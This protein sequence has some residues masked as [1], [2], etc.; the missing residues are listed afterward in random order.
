MNRTQQ[1]RFYSYS[2][3]LATL[4]LAAACSGDSLEREYAPPSGDPAEVEAVYERNF[5]GTTRA[6]NQTLKTFTLFVV[7]E[8]YDEEGPIAD[9][10]LET[11]NEETGKWESYPY[12]YLLDD[13]QNAYA[14]APSTSLEN[15]QNPVFTYDTQS[16]KYT[17]PTT[18]QSA[19]KIASRLDFT[20]TAVNN[21]LVMTFRDALF[22]LQFQAVNEIKD[23]RIKVKS[24]TLHNILPTGTWNF[25]KKNESTGQWTV[26][27]TANTRVNYTQEFETPVELERTKYKNITDSAFVFMPQD[28]YE[29]IWYPPDNDWGETGEEFADAQTN[30]HLY[31]EVKCQI[32]QEKD[33]K[34]LYLWGYPAAEASASKPEFESVFFPYDEYACLSDWMQGINS[35]YFLEFN[36]ITGGYDDQGKHITPHPTSGGASEFENA[37]PVKFVL[38]DDGNV[39]SWIVPGSSEVITVSGGWQKQNE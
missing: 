4:F 20:K 7:D 11:K 15:L 33:G 19:V 23:V 35:V 36:T 2:L 24:F 22:T 34:E 14:V 8:W 5:G 32:I 3:G 30:K 28:L 29:Y 16:F 25:D 1:H 38:G 17:V 21:R 6:M 9:N 27:Y 13:P 26:D 10:I 39:D 18:E 37:E 31:I 12:F